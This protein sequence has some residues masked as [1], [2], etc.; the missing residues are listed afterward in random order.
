MGP[1][2]KA[3]MEFLDAGG[4]EVI[5]TSPERMEDAVNGRAG[6]TIHR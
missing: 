5:I 6:T 4:E 3:A 1:K 2:I